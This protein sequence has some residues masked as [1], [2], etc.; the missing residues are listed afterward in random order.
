[1]RKPKR[2]V[3]GALIALVILAAL[4]ASPYIFLNQ[5]KQTLDAAARAGVPGE[6]IALSA[7]TTHFEW[8]GPAD[9]QVVV[10]LHGVSVPSFI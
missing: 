1:M 3:R 9:G 10:L 6:F 4:L 2:F 8:A 7:G 5:E